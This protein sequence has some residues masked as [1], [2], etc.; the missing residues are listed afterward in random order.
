MFEVYL[1]MID[2]CLRNDYASNSKLSEEYKNGIY[3]YVGQAVLKL[4]IKKQY[5]DCFDP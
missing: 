5:I 3:I 1:K 4:L 2:A